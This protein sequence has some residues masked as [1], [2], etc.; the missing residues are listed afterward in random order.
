[1][2][3]IYG[4]TVKSISND[5]YETFCFYLTYKESTKLSQCCIDFWSS[6]YPAQFD[7]VY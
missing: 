2:P 6:K 5:I 7:E 1:M 4:K 3:L